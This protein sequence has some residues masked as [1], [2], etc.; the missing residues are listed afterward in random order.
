MTDWTP[1]VRFHEALTR[2]SRS[3]GT[4]GDTSPLLDQFG[5]T[6]LFRRI[7]VDPAPHMHPGLVRAQRLYT[8]LFLEHAHRISG[9]LERADVG[10]FF[11]K[12]VALMGAVYQPG[13]R[14]LG[15]IDVYI[16]PSER[17][18]VIAT[19]HDLGYQQ[20][21]DRD[22]AGPESM[23]TALALEYISRGGA[24]HVAVDLHWSLDPL[25][26]LLPR[27]GVAIPVPFWTRLERRFGI[28]VPSSE[29]HAVLLTHHLVHTDLLHV[30]GLLDLAFV[31][32]DF[33]VDGGEDFHNT[34]TA[35]GIG[36]FA[37]TT[38]RLIA[39]DLGVQRDAAIGAARDRPNRFL[40]SLTLTRWLEIAARSPRDD[41]DAFT[42]SRVRRRLDLLDSAPY[43]TIGADVLLP[44]RS[45]LRWRW[46]KPMWRA[47][48]SHYRQILRKALGAL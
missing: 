45:F 21:S 41:L 37:S 47:W 31:F 30:R 36:R 38:A 14:T 39:Q 8:S 17:S 11:A 44:P 5:L 29:D 12:G 35:L 32:Q 2:V 24:E 27:P 46:G 3:L 7:D 1:A 6:G 19:L 25:D 4:P 20:L 43:R 10:H 23:R 13:D 16:Q 33:A 40:R 48:A 42:A 15:D 18:T 34:T 28:S 26:R 22:Q 9:A